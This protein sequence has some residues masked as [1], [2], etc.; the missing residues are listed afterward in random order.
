[1]LSRRVRTGRVDR[2]NL[3]RVTGGRA[4]RTG[5]SNHEENPLVR[6][7][8]KSSRFDLFALERTDFYPVETNGPAVP[9][10][11]KI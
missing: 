10:E 5:S 4:G 6:A 3:R 2:A 8:E 9:W 11:R 1:M 7:H